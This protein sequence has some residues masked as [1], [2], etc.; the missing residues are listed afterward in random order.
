MAQ[1]LKK[2]FP[3]LEIA[4]N[5]D[6]NFRIG[7]FELVLDGELLWSKLDS[8]N[9]PTEEEAVNLIQEHVKA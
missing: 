7:S 8:G 6:G 3:D 4:G 5:E 1:D 9:F 2:H